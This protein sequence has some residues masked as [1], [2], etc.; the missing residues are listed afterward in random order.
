MVDSFTAAPT[1]APPP[2]PPTVEAGGDANGVLRMG[3]N[4]DDVKALQAKLNARGEMLPVNGRFGP[5]TFEAVRRFQL[6]NGIQANGIVGPGTQRA[7]FAPEQKS[8]WGPVIRDLGPDTTGVTFRPSDWLE[9]ALSKPGA[10][11]PPG[12]AVLEK[13][14]DEGS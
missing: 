8:L 6:A 7:L 9:K 13:D 11:L 5:R 2:A 12:A 4:G 1:S 14:D 10:G 3:A